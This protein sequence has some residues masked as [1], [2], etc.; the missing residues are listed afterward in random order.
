MS[1]KVSS[2]LVQHGLLR[3]SDLQ[4][5]FTRQ[6]VRGG[7]LDTIL[8]ERQLVAE[9]DLLALLANALQ[10]PPLS[11]GDF[12][13]ASFAK[14]AELIPEQDVRRYGACPIGIDER[15]LRVVVGE[16]SDLEGLT[17]L[18]VAGEWT[19]ACY[20][21]SEVRVVQACQRVYGSKPGRRFAR[22]LNTVGEALPVPS[23]LADIEEIAE[24]LAPPPEQGA[25]DLGDVSP[26]LS[27]VSDPSADTSDLSGRA[28]DLSGRAS[29]LSGDASDLSCDASDLSGDEQ[30]AAPIDLGDERP[31]VRVNMA[32]L[33]LGPSDGRPTEP[34]E[35][36]QSDAAPGQHAEQRS[37]ARK[38]T[39]R[40]PL[41]ASSI[42][43]ESKGAG[44]ATTEGRLAEDGANNGLSVRPEG[45]ELDEEADATLMTPVDEPAQ[46][47]A[48]EFS[49]EGAADSDTEVTPPE[50]LEALHT[51]EVRRAANV[52][53]ATDRYP[54]VTGTIASGR[55]AVAANAET[56]P[57]PPLP[58]TTGRTER[59]P[60]LEEGGP[61]QPQRNANRKPTD[62]LPHIVGERSA[63]P[64]AP[65]VKAAATRLE[66][67]SAGSLL[68]RAQGGAPEETPAISHTAISQPPKGPGSTPARPLELDEALLAMSA[69][70]SRDDV[71]LSLLRGAHRHLPAID[72]FVTQSGQLIGRF[73]MRDNALEGRLIRAR[74]VSLVVPSV[75]SRAARDG[76]I[77]IGPAPD[78]DASATVLL[79]A[80]IVAP[81][82]AIVPVQLKGRTVCVL[83]GHSLDHPIA[84]SARGALDRLAS[85]AS[86]ALVAHI[87]RDKRSRRHM[88]EPM[89][90]PAVPPA[91]RG[92]RGARGPLKPK[93]RQG[94]LQTS[95]QIDGGKSRR[96]SRRGE[97]APP[98]PDG[99]VIVNLDASVLE[100]SIED[101]LDTVETNGAQT[102]DALGELRNRGRQAIE[103]VLKQFPGQLRFDRTQTAEL[104]V[105]S[106]CSTVLQVLVE[107]GRPVVSS[108]APL[109]VHGDDDIRFY[110]TYLLSELTFPESVSLLAGRL[111]DLDPAVRHAAA[112]GL[113][114]C[115]ELSQYQEIISDLRDDLAH[116]SLR[117][118]IAAMAALGALGDVAATP[119]LIAQLQDEEPS[120]AEAAWSALVTLTKQD[121]GR[122]VR[123]WRT[124]WEEHRVQ[125]RVEW[126]IEGLI[127]ASREIRE[128]ASMELSEVTG[129]ALNFDPDMDP[130]DRE[131]IH[132]QMLNW[133]SEA[134][135]LDFGRFS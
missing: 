125:H 102:A 62:P 121:F 135:M 47:A 3:V 115:R 100:Q 20:A 84:P 51:V 32:R 42:Q 24:E 108:L 2:L 7:A 110:A 21:A 86:K 34:V 132:R 117:P 131:A 89:A 91:P 9:G 1:S 48:L 29:D 133:W 44:D 112:Y 45:E 35:P 36:L 53:T 83:I 97:P 58:G 88:T 56:P 120:A 23:V 77:Y 30:L 14:L 68:T 122:D 64:T 10:L 79:D 46:R 105:V 5:A 129:I 116:P 92:T 70:S 75:V 54:V 50:V 73:S 59:Y 106:E 39:E 16:E 87:V 93:K 31:T 52:H 76:S 18:A 103:G 90:R 41:L 127:H 13:P 11:A 104:P 134:G 113:R 126:L 57:E 26:H 109:L 6:V 63:S 85:E 111:S 8:L 101:L 107:L 19:L 81:H 49:R 37:T 78:T 17:K 114:R 4:D 25:P 82:L 74:R 71:L 130:P 123:G 95:G 65:T 80:E 99:K 15:L 43:H 55:D 27:D 38:P 69:A 119:S 40:L 124:W 60:T 28:S 61:Q 72:L 94:G 12:D 98:A 128:A 67:S 33:A 118:R 96:A 22:L 66:L